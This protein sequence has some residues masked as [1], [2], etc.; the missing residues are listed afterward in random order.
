M[1]F[2]FISMDYIKSISREMY[3]L[4]ATYSEP[5]LDPTPREA[6]LWL[7]YGYG[8]GSLYRDIGCRTDPRQGTSLFA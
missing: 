6:S 8:Y 4:F 1:Q 5:C 2:L 3:A 7:T